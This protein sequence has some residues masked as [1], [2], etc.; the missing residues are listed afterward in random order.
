MEEVVKVDRYSDGIMRIR[1]WEIT[2]GKELWNVI[3]AFVLQLG[4]PWEESN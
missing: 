2:V 4:R 1:K 3:S